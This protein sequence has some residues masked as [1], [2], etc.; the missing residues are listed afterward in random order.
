MSPDLDP[1]GIIEGLAGSVASVSEAMA[2]GQSL[3]PATDR[4]FLVAAGSSNRAMLGLEYWLE[5]CSPS[6]EVRRYFPAEF[7]AKAPRRLDKGTL[8]LLASKSGATPETVAAAE[9]LHRLPCQTVA[10]TQ[11]ADSPLARTVETHFLIGPTAESF[12]GIFMVMQ[13]LAGG[14]L[15]AK[16]GWPDAGRLRDSL[17]AL[18]EAIAAAASEADARAAADAHA[19][20]DDRILYHVA[21]GPGFTTAYVFGVC[22]L[23]EMLWIHS[24]PIEAAEFFHGPFEV[25][26][27]DTPLVL[28]LGEDP[29]RPLMERVLAFCRRH[30]ERL[31]VYDSRNFAMPGVDARIRPIVAPYVLQAALKRVAVHLSRL[32]RHPLSTRR[33]MG[34]TDY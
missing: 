11:S 23:M 29:S 33:Y 2:L 10:F 28:I 8:V 24:Y 21:S 20:R 7:T 3:A 30:A 1:T 32:H 12:T 9:F 5:R 16:D 34:K 26:E 25:V 13:S 31:F 6:L 27:R 17:N 15:A 19:L 22:V 14:L 18:P 4:L